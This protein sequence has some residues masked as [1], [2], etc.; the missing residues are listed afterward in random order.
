MR[1]VEVR[2]ES[3]RRVSW[4]IGS[5][6]D[7]GGEESVERVLGEREERRR[8]VSVLWLAGPFLWTISGGGLLLLLFLHRGTYQYVCETRYCG[9]Q[10]PGN[11]AEGNGGS[12][13]MRNVFFLQLHQKLW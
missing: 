3:L 10:E 13:V 11:D 1:E 6:V 12:L 8:G 9:R 7:E 5:E 4:E 2:R